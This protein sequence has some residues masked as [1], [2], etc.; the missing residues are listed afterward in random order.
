MYPN[1]QH[2][3]IIS[4]YPLTL[5]RQQHEEHMDPTVNKSLIKGEWTSNFNICLS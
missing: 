1:L 4:A 3:T 2:L 5:S